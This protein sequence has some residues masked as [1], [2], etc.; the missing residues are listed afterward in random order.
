MKTA[1]DPTTGKKVYWDGQQWLPL[2]TATNPQTGAQV[3]IVGGQ[4]FPIS[5]STATP[6]TPPLLFGLGSPEAVQ[7]TMGT[8]REEMQKFGPEVS[9]R[10]QIIMGDDPSLLEQLVKSPELAL[11]AGSQAARAGGATLNTYLGTLIPNAVK[12]GAEAA[13][14]RVKDTDSFRLAAQAASLGYEGYQAFK[15]FLPEIAERFEAS[16]DVGLLF[17]PR[18]DLPK[19]PEMKK[20]AQE[21]S[22]RLVKEKKKDGVTLLL[23]P[24][25]PEM[26]DVFEEKGVLRTKTWQPGD[27]DNL[28]IDT[29]TDMKGVKPTRSYT[30][31]YREIQK[32]TDAAKQATDK[33]ITAQNKPID[34]DVLLESMQETIDEVLKDPITQAASGDIQQQLEVMSRIALESVEAYGTDLVG[35]LEARRRF[36]EVVGNFD[37]NAKARNIAARKIRGVLND[38]LKDNTRGDQLHNLLTKQFHGITAMEEMLPKRTGEARDAVSR[39]VRSLQSVD[40]L[41]NTVLA[42]GA[43]GTATLGAVGGAVPATAAGALGLTVYSGI[44]MAKPRNRARAYAAMLSAID[45]AIPLTKGSA[46][47]ELEMD[48]LIIVDLIDQTRQEIKEEES[49]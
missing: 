46:L 8:A 45:K 5:T 28:V 43:T 30:Y 37:G 48:R 21:K 15:Q 26:R 39:A 20:G 23:E 31:N 10:A 22:Q 44:Q 47:K 29:I 25:S 9:R 41:P 36:D 14:D 7:K 35:V 49:E 24:V 27:F 32:E 13:Y 16:V 6:T 40:L 34:S 38:T 18:P 19:I 42:L 11:I 33:M 3:G 4:T 12:E 1:T 17:S 2:K